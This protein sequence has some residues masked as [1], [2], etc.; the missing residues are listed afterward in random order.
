[1]ICTAGSAKS[2]SYN[3]LNKVMGLFPKATEQRGLLQSVLSE[4]SQHSSQVIRRSL[5]EHLQAGDS[6]LPVPESGAEYMDTH[7][8]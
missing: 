5:C 7:T 2:N 4:S 3:D 8:I 1:M 6:L